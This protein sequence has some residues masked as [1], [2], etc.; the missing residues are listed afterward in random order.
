[1]KSNQPISEERRRCATVSDPIR[2][3]KKQYEELCR[4]REQ[5]QI[6]ES[7]QRVLSGGMP[8]KAPSL[9]LVHTRPPAAV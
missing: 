4:L 9:K 7:R 5:V 3:L 6:A 1:M 2:N 8:H